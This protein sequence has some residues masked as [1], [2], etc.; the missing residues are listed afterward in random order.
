MKPGCPECEQLRRE[1][2]EGADLSDLLVRVTLHE[3]EAHPKQPLR[4]HP[5]QKRM[6][7]R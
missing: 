5:E 2:R 7:A 6:V 4:Q 1:Y 3:A